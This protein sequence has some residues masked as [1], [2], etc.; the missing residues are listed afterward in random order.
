MTDRERKKANNWKVEAKRKANTEK[1]QEKYEKI[2]KMFQV[3][4]EW[5]LQFFKLNSVQFSS[6]AQSCLTLCDP[7]NRSIPGLHVHHPLLEFTQ[8]HVHWFTTSNTLKCC[9]VIEI[10]HIS[11]KWLWRHLAWVN[12]WK[13]KSEISVS[14][15]QIHNVT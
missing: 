5:G 3:D 15:M 2:T 9:K 6:V 8:T 1:V 7:M 14:L 11:K 12:Y 4:C 13:S 10:G